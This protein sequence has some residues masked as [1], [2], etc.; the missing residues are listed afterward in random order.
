MLIGAARRREVVG[1]PSAARPATE[2]TIPSFPAPAFRRNGVHSQAPLVP[3]RILTGQPAIQAPPSRQGRRLYRLQYCDPPRTRPVGMLCLIRGQFSLA[4]M[5][6][7]SAPRSE[8]DHSASQRLSIVV[9]FDV[10][11]PPPRYSANGI[12]HIPLSVNITQVLTPMQLLY[13]GDVRGKFPGYC[14]GRE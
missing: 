2:Q 14:A 1:R 3:H 4:A 11:L 10:C 13:F 5:S 7:T 8:S 12:E 9:T 6:E